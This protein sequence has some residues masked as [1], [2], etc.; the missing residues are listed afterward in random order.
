ME[1]G[2]RAASHGNDGGQRRTGI[3]GGAPRGG[4]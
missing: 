1:Q 3:G 2:P 4:N